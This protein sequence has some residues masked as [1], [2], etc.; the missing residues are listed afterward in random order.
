MS[1]SAPR[2]STAGPPPPPPLHRWA[3]LA[4]C[5]QGPGGQLGLSS[6]ARCLASAS[7]PGGGGPS[8][9]VYVTNVSGL[10]GN[11]PVLIGMMEYFQVSR[12]TYPRILM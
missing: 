2:S 11:S 7:P 9:S 6:S 8:N 10:V 5:A 12:A 4:S 3:A 1:R